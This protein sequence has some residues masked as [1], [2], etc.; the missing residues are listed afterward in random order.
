MHVCLP[1]HPPAAHPPLL[2]STTHPP[3]SLKQTPR[4]GFLKCRFALKGGGLLWR[5]LAC[6]HMFD[7][8][9]RVCRTGCHP[10]RTRL[11]HSETLSRPPH[12][13]PHNR[14]TISWLLIKL[15]WLSRDA[16]SR[17]WNQV[18]VACSCTHVVGRVYLVDY[19]KHSIRFQ[20]LIGAIFTPIWRP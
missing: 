6:A 1:R 17:S 7:H 15:H 12:Y 3:L 20:L 16:S 4:C 2:P 18:L 5:L 13:Q 19:L 8:V 14:T 10:A 11:L 9:C